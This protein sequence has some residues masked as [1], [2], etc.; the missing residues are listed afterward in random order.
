M[1]NPYVILEVV[2]ASILYATLFFASK[3]PVGEQFN[4]RK[5]VSTIVVGVG[6]GVSLWLAGDPLNEVSFQAQLGA[7]GALV[8]LVE[9]LILIMVRAYRK[10]RGPDVPPPEYSK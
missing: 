8:A 2:F 3:Y 9:R 4:L 1:N 6:V 10:Q 7:Y 5:Y